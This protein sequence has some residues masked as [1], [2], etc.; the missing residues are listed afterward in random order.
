MDEL[1]RLR[2]L[3]GLTQAELGQI[4]GISPTGVNE[5][6]RGRREP[7]ASTLRKLARAL[8]IEIRDF[9][10]SARPAEISPEELDELLLA[11]RERDAEAE[12]IRERVR[13]VVERVKARQRA[14][15]LV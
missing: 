8:D 9:Y 12:E 7:R 6:E 1:R 4:A 14:K 3:R 13:R 15:D 5:I 10:P 2:R 11:V